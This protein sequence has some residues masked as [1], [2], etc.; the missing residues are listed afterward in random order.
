MSKICKI[1]VCISV[2]SQ[3]HKFSYKNFEYVAHEI[4]ENGNDANLVKLTRKNFENT[5]SQLFFSRV[6]L[7]FATFVGCKCKK[8]PAEKKLTC[9]QKFF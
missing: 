2:T 1:G 3:F 7:T 5:S 8:S 4:T 9:F 6:F